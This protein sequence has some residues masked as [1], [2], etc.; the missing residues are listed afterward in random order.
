MDT[1]EIHAEART[2]AVAVIDDH[3]LVCDALAA[4][5]KKKLDW[6]VD[7]YTSIEAALECL[8]NKP[9]DLIVTDYLLPG[10]SG[11]RGVSRLWQLK[12]APVVVLTSYDDPEVRT[13]ALA[14]GAVDFISKSDGVENVLR[15]LQ[16][17]IGIVPPKSTI[18][19][20]DAGQMLSPMQAEI[21]DLICDGR[22]NRAICQATGLP[23]AA[24]KRRISEIC[25]LAGVRNRTGLA[26]WWRSKF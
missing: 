16:R 7:V 14:A 8:A 13:K 23:E 21:A 25:R 26:L 17:N 12:L 10:L 3:L 19:S 20:F 22:S 24:I 6:S 9:V 1:L 2:K 15:R 5:L 11:A 4:M 18:I